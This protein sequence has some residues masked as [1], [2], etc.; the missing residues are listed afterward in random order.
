MHKDK[1]EKRS[2]LQL[3]IRIDN[4]RI[5]KI[6]SESEK[7]SVGIRQSSLAHLNASLRT[8]QKLILLTLLE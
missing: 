8:T 5:E 1:K 2:H 7:R 3:V 6:A 4:I